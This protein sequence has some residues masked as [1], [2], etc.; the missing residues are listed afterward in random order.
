[1]RV[2]ELLSRALLSVIGRAGSPEHHLD[3]PLDKSR[4]EGISGRMYDISPD[5]RRFVFLKPV[6]AGEQPRVPDSVVVVQR[7]TSELARALAERPSA[8]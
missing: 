5:G 7:W 4:L 6:P 2:A 3:S 1:M 8:P